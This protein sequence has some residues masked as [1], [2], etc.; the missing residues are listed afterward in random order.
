MVAQVITVQAGNQFDSPA[1]MIVPPV[2]Q[3][4]DFYPV[5][6]PFTDTNSNLVYVPY[7]ML[8]VEAGQEGNV[9]VEDQE[10]NLQWQ[11]LTS[12]AGYQYMGAI[13]QVRAM[14]SFVNKINR[15]A[16]YKS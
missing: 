14:T 5:V 2:E 7:L 12:Q 9:R 1:S 15:K 6:I 8:V 13:F 3:Y 4:Q 11:P 16:I 10:V